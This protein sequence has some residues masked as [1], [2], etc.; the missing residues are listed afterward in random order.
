MSSEL[1]SLIADLSKIK[2][3]HVDSRLRHYT[4]RVDYR[5]ITARS[6][7]VIVIVIS[8]FIIPISTNFLPENALGFSNKFVISAASLLIGLVSALQELFK[9]ES[10]WHQYS[11]RIIEI[12][13]AIGL[14][15]LEIAK[16]RQLSD[17]NEAKL[18]VI[19]ATKWLV[20]T[21]NQA[22]LSEMEVFFTRVK[23]EKTQDEQKE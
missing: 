16:S 13:L 11:T 10:V 5:R 4:E 18:T 3:E 9:W 22:V 2:E 17:E 15:K 1:E 20:R 8:L 23:G 6:T 12:E 7:S 19:E 21:V 14:W